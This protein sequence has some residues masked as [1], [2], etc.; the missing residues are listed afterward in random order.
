MRPELKQLDFG[1]SEL[2]QVNEQCDLVMH[3]RIPKNRIT[4]GINGFEALPKDRE[5]FQ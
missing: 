1:F 3:S 2:T 4:F 5:S